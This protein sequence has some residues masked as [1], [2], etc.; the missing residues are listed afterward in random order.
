MKIAIL[1]TGAVGATLGTKLVSLGHEVRMGSRSAT[2]EKAQA[3]ARQAGPRASYGSFGDAAS[4]GADLVINATK[5]D[6][7][8]EALRAAG[9]PRLRGKIV[10]DVANP[11]DFSR[12]MPPTL[13][14]ANTD[15][16]GEQIQRAFPGARV[17]KAL[18]TINA[19]VMVAPA[20]VPGD[21]DT[22]VCGNDEAAKETVTRLLRDFG[23][24]HVIDLGDIS[25]SRATE[26][27]LALWVRLYGVTKTSRFNVHVARRPPE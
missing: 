17:V 8:L 9:E 14:V 18:N 24:K 22:F 5:G 6:S 25:A 15:S 21:H 3:W 13:T 16:L 26:M 19:E 7:S 27:Y 10:I 11:L 1:G 23:W 12:G 20:L 4:F 2:S